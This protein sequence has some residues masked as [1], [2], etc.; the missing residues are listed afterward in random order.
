MFVLRPKGNEAEMN[1]A[2][3]NPSQSA[4]DLSR[5]HHSLPSST[6]RTSQHSSTG[7]HDVFPHEAQRFKSFA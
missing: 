1:V 4:H 7:L 6:L 3:A 2:T 5:N